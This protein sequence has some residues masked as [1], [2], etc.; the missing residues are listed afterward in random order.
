MKVYNFIGDVEQDSVAEIIKNV[1]E[2]DIVSITSDGGDLYLGFAGYEKLKPLNV[3]TLGAGNVASAGALL[4]AAGLHRVSTPT[5]RYLLHEPWAI[6]EGTGDEM[7]RKGELMNIEK[8][9]LIIFFSNILTI[10]VDEIRELFKKNDWIDANEALRIGLVTE[11]N[12]N[13]K[14]M[15]KFFNEILNRLKVVEKNAVSVKDKAGVQYDFPDID[16]PDQI[17][18]G[19]AVKNADGSPFTGEI[20]LT[21]GRTIVAE[22]GKVISMQDAEPAGEPIP[23]MDEAQKE[24]INQLSTMVIEQSKANKELNKLISEQN[25][26]IGALS[27]RVTEMNAFL[28][29]PEGN[30][31]E[32]T[33]AA[34]KPK[35]GQFNSDG[36]FSFKVK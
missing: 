2:G 11:I 35:T 26:V 27:N 20:L 31:I 3:T 33:P 16:S 30:K 22:A 34:G 24:V 10:G 7:V 8:E 5:A 15:S 6:V 25:K 12:D 29:S 1:S 32:P 14:F 18:V 23:A 13:T 28:K 4:F 19:T 36:S 17:A 9:K 21:D